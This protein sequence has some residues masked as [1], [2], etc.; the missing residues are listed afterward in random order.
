MTWWRPALVPV[1]N[2]DQL[3][4]DVTVLG[5]N[6]GAVLS[7]LARMETRLMASLDDLQAAV[8]RNG[9]AVAGAV[10]AL[11]D[12]RAKIA[13][14]QAAVDAGDLDEARIAALTASIDASSDAV[15]Q[16]L[17]P[18]VADPDTPTGD[19]APPPDTNPDTV[20]PGSVDGAVPAGEPAPEA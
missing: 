13:A 2:L 10:T 5:H 9:S 12:Q 17:A 6:L 1:R 15:A 18:V 4:A 20:D 19:T 14:L 8:E 16:A 11:T 7:Q 3:V